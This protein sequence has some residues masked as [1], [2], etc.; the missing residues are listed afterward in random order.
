MNQ[1]TDKQIAKI[2]KYLARMTEAQQ[3]AYVQKLEE[4]NLLKGIFSKFGS[5]KNNVAKFEKNKTE[6]L[7][8]LNAIKNIIN[9]N[10]TVPPDQKQK[11]MAGVD[12][13]INQVNALKVPDVTSVDVP[14]QE[15]G[16]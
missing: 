11:D 14:E 10:Q 3:D 15:Q 5:A 4:V 7:T 6:L 12:K 13:I 9:Q 2:N 16:K 1:L 8:K